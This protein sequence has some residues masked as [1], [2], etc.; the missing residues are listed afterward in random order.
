MAE[1][2]IRL[3]KS[4]RL[5]VA[6][7]STFLQASWNYERMQ[8]LGF[9]YAMMPALKKLYKNKEDRAAALTRHM[10]FFNSQWNSRTIS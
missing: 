6:W 7:R 3:S 10:E 8:N 1:E 4:D 5:S 2:K 9:A